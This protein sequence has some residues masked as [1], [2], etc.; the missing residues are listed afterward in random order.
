MTI[1][2]TCLAHLRYVLRTQVA[3]SASPVLQAPTKKPKSGS[4]KRVPAKRERSDDEHAE[5]KRS[6][7]SSKKHKKGSS[8][9]RRGPSR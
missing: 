7:S 4:S 9:V 8:K 5:G 1:P 2:T 3:D 6:K